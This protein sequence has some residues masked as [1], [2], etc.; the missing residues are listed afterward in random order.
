MVVTRHPGQ[1]T[2]RVQD[3]DCGSVQATKALWLKLRNI[4][5]KSARKHLSTSFIGDRAVLMKQNG[6]CEDGAQPRLTLWAFLNF[7]AVFS[8]VYLQDLSGRGRSNLEL[9]H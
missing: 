5:V 1:V 4:S 7:G 2:G 8:N 9:L 3:L 6:R